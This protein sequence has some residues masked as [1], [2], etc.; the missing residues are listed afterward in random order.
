M[1]Y[2]NNNTNSNSQQFNNNYNMN[3][4]DISVPAGGYLQNFFLFKIALNQNN[5]RIKE[6]LNK[7]WLTIYY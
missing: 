6:A 1:L 4:I 2:Y 3:I 7:F 5:S